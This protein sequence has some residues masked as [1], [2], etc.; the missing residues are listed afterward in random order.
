MIFFYR[1]RD[2][3]G[4]AKGQGQSSEVLRNRQNKS[5]NK[6]SRANH[7]RKQGNSYKQSKGMF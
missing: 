2:V 7:N 5:I 1:K 3:V 4:E 6:S